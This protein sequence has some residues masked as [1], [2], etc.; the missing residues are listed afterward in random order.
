MIGYLGLHYTVLDHLDVKH[1][2]NMV[3]VT[4][5]VNVFPVFLLQ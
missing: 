4:L 3:N 5:L 2:D 1:A